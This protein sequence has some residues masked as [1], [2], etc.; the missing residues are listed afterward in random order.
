MQAAGSTNAD[1]VMARMREM[2]IDDFM[3]QQGSLRIDPSMRPEPRHEAR[4]GHK[5]EPQLN[6]RGGGP[7][8]V[9]TNLGILEPDENG[10]LTLAALHPG[11]AVEKVLE[12][13]G[14]K[15]KVASQLRLTEPP[16]LAELRMLRE[17]LDPQKIY[18]K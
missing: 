16:S 11:V 1:K 14:W 18:L 15:L 7:Q 10:E 9:V 13:T 17:E 8:A 6:L 5:V 2:P 4:G 12:N 3:T